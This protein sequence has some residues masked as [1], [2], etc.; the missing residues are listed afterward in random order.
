MNNVIAGPQ[1]QYD[2]DRTFTGQ[3]CTTFRQA[4]ISLLSGKS[5]IME[6]LKK[7]RINLAQPLWLV[8]AP[9]DCK[10]LFEELEIKQKLPGKMPVDQLILFA[11]DSGVLAKWIPKLA[12]YIVRDT[13]FWIAY[14]K[15]TGAIVSDLIQ[16]KPWDIVFQSGYR[17]QTSI[18]INGDWT[19]MRFT[20][21]PKSKPSIFDLPIEERKVEG[22]DFVNRTVLLPAD[23]LAAVRKHGM[24]AFFNAMAFTHKKEH[25]LAIVE[26]KKEETRARRIEKMIEML[27]ENMKKQIPNSRRKV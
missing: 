3:R 16:M 18:S 21:A 1:V 6:L 24:E 17:G 14:P 12:S 13:L 27:A 20:N 4:F 15:K 19:G 9:V 22:I 5:G 11:E 8:N 25:V 7:L 26:A 23:A 10:L 2:V